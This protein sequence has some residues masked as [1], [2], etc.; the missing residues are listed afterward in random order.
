MP[1]ARR[2]FAVR[3]AS[4]SKERQCGLREL[5]HD[6][7]S[8]VTLGRAGLVVIDLGLTAPQSDLDHG[9]TPKMAES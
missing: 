4:G 1:T 9:G 7:G 6:I 2:S 5:L 8:D 3:G